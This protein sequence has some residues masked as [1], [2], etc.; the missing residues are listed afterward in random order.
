MASP[1]GLWGQL[2]KRRKL[3]PTT[4]GLDAL[5]IALLAWQKEAGSSS[6]DTLS[7]LQ[8]LQDL[9]L[10]HYKEVNG[11]ISKLGKSIDKTVATNVGLVLHRISSRLVEEA[12]HT[13]LITEGS[14]GAAKLMGK[15]DASAHGVVEAALREMRVV[16]EALQAHNLPP[17]FAWLERHRLE[18]EARGSTLKFTLHQLEFTQLLQRGALPRPPACPPA[19]LPA[20]A[21]TAPAPS[22]VRTCTSAPPC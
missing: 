4:A 2:A 10:A 12:V 1:D 17:A 8:S 11:T 22:P 7:K 21:A 14:F 15:E 6:I 5:I 20:A 19:G 13:H 9:T 18:L 16:L 3:E